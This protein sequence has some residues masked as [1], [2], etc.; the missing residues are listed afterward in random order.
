M[1]LNKYLR[2]KRTGFCASEENLKRLGL[3]VS[4]LGREFSDGHGQCLNL[5]GVIGGLVM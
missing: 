5:P 3:T 2:V 1:R 4:Y